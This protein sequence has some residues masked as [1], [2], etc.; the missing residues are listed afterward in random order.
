M[1]M[2]HLKYDMILNLSLIVSKL[3]NFASTFLYFFS[4][5]L[6]FVLRLIQ[7]QMHFDTKTNSILNKTI[8]FISNIS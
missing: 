4:F 8:L 1:H 3:K 5:D 6:E 2:S 7:I